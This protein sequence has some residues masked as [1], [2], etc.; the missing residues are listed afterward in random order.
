MQPE[1]N[2]TNEALLYISLTDGK[3]IPVG[4]CFLLPSSEAKANPRK[5]SINGNAVNRR[6]WTGSTMKCEVEACGTG[7]FTMD[8]G[9]QS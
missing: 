7:K 2:V 5:S 8:S 6:H 3:H 9:V 4:S 1:L